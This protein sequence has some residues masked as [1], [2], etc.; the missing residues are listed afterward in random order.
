MKTRNF[1]EACM[2][3]SAYL[4][5]LKIAIQAVM[6]E[7]RVKRR[8]PDTEERKAYAEAGALLID[9]I[10]SLTNGDVVC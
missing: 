1:G 10:H 3:C 7:V 9:E 4:H 5:L 6:L 8:S 2:F